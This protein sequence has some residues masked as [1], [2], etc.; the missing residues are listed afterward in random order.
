MADTVVSLAKVLVAVVRV[1]QGINRDDEQAADRDILD[2]FL[3]D[4][5]EKEDDSGRQTSR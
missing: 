1:L 3:L 4:H 5:E 2:E